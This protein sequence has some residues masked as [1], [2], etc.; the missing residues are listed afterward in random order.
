[1]YIRGSP[2][3]DFVTAD[4]FRSFPDHTSSTPEPEDLTE[5]PEKKSEAI[6]RARFSLT[7][8]AETDRA[9]RK[10]IKNIIFFMAETF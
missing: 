6:L 2:E 5:T 7:G 4:S 1:M 8:A 3:T 9:S 10:D